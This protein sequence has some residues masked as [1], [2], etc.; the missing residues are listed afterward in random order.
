[1][2][3]H[4][5]V[6]LVGWWFYFFSILVF[7]TI[8]Q[9]R[10]IHIFNRINKFPKDWLIFPLNLSIYTYVQEPSLNEFRMIKW[11]RETMR[12]KRQFQSPWIFS[13]KNLRNCKTSHGNQI[14]W[15]NGKLVKS[16]KKKTNDKDINRNCNIKTGNRK[17]R[18]NGR[19]IVFF[20]FCFALVAN[21]NVFFVYVLVHKS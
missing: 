6:C 10:A 4:L 8:A 13:R 20:W 14:V 12:D 21:W 19:G 3:V 16:T 9:V 2:F 7:I 11:D 5:F 1:M 15:G 17:L 18:L